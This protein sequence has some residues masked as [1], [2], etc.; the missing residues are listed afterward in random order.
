MPPTVCP[1]VEPTDRHA[2]QTQARGPLGITHAYSLDD[3]AQFS[4]LLSHPLVISVRQRFTGPLQERQCCSALGRN[5]CLFVTPRDRR[6]HHGTA[7]AIYDMT[8]PLESIDI[9]ELCS[10]GDRDEGSM[11]MR[12]PWAEAL[13][14]TSGY[15]LNHC[16][17]GPQAGYQALQP[18]FPRLRG[19]TTERRGQQGY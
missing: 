16:N 3:D 10:M 6:R 18:H 15:G 19:M 17:E 2:G 4:V 13:Y 7:P 9:P 1:L 12:V 11:Q 14:A 5:I 8:M